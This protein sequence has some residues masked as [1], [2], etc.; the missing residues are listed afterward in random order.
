MDNDLQVVEPVHENMA[1]H[2][3]ITPGVDVDLDMQPSISRFDIVYYIILFCILN[4]IMYIF[5]RIYIYTYIHIISYSYS[6]RYVIH[7]LQQQPMSMFDSPIHL[8]L[9]SSGHPEVG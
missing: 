3:I 4:H 2:Y 7:V 6:Y 8:R 1:H 9:F 5:I